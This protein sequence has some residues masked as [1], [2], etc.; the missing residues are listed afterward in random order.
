[1][2]TK[3]YCWVKKNSNKWNHIRVVRLITKLLKTLLKFNASG[4]KYGFSLSNLFFWLLALNFKSL[5]QKCT[6]ESKID[7]Q[8]KTFWKC[9]PGHF[10]CS[11]P[12]R[13]LSPLNYFRQEPRNKSNQNSTSAQSNIIISLSDLLYFVTTTK[14]C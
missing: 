5:I 11:T 4:L 7:V 8:S 10:Y 3:G 9:P 12:P 1:M 6:L 2:G 13:V 14:A